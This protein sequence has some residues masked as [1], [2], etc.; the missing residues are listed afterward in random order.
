[1][2][3]AGKPGAVEAIPVMLRNGKAKTMPKQLTAHA[4]L[5]EDPKR[6]VERIK[7][8][9]IVYVRLQGETLGQVYG[10]LGMEP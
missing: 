1:M 8:G 2:A 10:L 5:E 4:M 9:E 3:H 6:A 7:A